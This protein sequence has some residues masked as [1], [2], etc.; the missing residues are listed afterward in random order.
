MLCYC[1]ANGKWQTICA[2]D[3]GYIDWCT[4]FIRLL[5]RFVLNGI[6]LSSMLILNL[7]IYLFNNRMVSVI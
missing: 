2:L 4:V 1:I 6:V 5:F 3:F 7:R